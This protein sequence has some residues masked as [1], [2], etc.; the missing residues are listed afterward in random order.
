MS[1]LLINGC[2]YAYTWG[3]TLPAELGD[4]LGFDETVNLGHRGGSNNRTFR[5][6]VEYIL[7][8]DSVEFVILMLTFWGRDEG[9]WVIPTPIEGPWISHGT[10]LHP[11]DIG[12]NNR[13]MDV[14]LDW[15]TKYLEL[16]TLIGFNKT[17]CCDVLI[18]DLLCLIGWLKSKNIK[19]CIF[20]ACDMDYSQD[21]LSPIKKRE[22][23]TDPRVINI[24]EWSSNKLLYENGIE[25]IAQDKK[26]SNPFIRHYNSDGYHILNDF[27]YNYITDNKLL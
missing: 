26:L 24:F 21:S 8:N 9:A 27:L 18:T 3:S 10:S 17:H 19:Y 4:K 14:P 1:S 6:T 12:V 22:L 7:E 13:I 15:V 2:S 23:L 25:C 20:G 5:T 16:K 11:C